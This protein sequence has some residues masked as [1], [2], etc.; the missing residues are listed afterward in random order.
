[1]RIQYNIKVDELQV[2]TSMLQ[3]T[4]MNLDVHKSEV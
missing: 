1:M 4:K 2:R 3:D